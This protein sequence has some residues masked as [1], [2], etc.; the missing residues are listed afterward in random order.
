MKRFRFRIVAGVV[1][2]Y[3]QI[4][5]I[6]TWIEH[7]T[8]VLIVLFWISRQHIAFILTSTYQVFQKA[9]HCIL[10]KLVSLLF[11]SFL[12]P[13]CHGQ[14]RV[15]PPE[16]FKKKFFIVLV[17]STWSSRDITGSKI[18]GFKKTSITQLTI[19]YVPT[20][21]NMDIV[22][23]SPYVPFIELVRKKDHQK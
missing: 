23:R 20:L 22:T 9:E 19:L 10:L 2:R 3:L 18:H 13:F 1:K 8:A 7:F 4:D 11:F 12:A 6:K 15:W 16:S 17:S 14:R 5:R 21:K